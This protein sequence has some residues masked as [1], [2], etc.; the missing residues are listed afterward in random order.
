MRDGGEGNDQRKLRDIQDLPAFS[1]WWCEASRGGDL[2][3]GADVEALGRS[4][5][6]PLDRENTL[7]NF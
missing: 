1:K 7:G 5:T 2:P 3:S 4:P 6:T